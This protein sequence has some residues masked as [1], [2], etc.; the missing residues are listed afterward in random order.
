MIK[1]DARL[2]GDFSPYPGLRV[3]GIDPGLAAACGRAAFATTVA[4][5]VEEARAGL[6]ATTAL[7]VRNGAGSRT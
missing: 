3:T 5:S 4:P 7:L 2:S 6:G 1:V